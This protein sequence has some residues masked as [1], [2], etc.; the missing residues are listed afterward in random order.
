VYLRN[1][2]LVTAKVTSSLF[3][4]NLITEAIGSSETSVLRRATLS[5]ITTDCIP[6]VL[7]YLEGIL[8]LEQ[9]LAYRCKQSY[10]TCK[11]LVPKCPITF[12]K[13]FPIGRIETKLNH[14]ILAGFLPTITAQSQNNS[15]VRA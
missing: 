3:R 10:A 12:H 11:L 13:T 9:L 7:R 6:K 15:D 5:H 8:P 4:L 2:L 1:V 14:V